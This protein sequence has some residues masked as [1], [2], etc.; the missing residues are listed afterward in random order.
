MLQCFRLRR[1]ASFCIARLFFTS[2]VG[3]TVLISTRKNWQRYSGTKQSP[4]RPKILFHRGNLRRR[5]FS[6]WVVKSLQTSLLP[7]I[8]RW[9]FSKWSIL[10]SQLESEPSRIVSRIFSVLGRL[11]PIVIY[12]PYFAIF[13]YR[14]IVCP[15]LSAPV[16]GLIQFRIY[17]VPFYALT[18][19]ALWG[20]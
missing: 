18:K 17:H 4:K 1:R 20:G 3:G 15:S 13:C 10:P 19:I 8:S 5:S 2:G 14:K 16:L 11:V 9:I 7:I 12:L 6:S